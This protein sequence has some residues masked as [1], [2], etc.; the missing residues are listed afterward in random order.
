[1][2]SGLAGGLVIVNKQGSPQRCSSPN[3]RNYPH[4]VS[5]ISYHFFDFL[6]SHTSNGV[7]A[8]SGHMKKNKKKNE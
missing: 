7:I 2:N 4:P 5:Q 8:N 6:F 3:S 1:M